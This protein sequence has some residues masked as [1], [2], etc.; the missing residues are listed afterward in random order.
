MRDLST[1]RGARREEIVNTTT[2]SNK[3]IL[4][5][6]PLQESDLATFLRTTLNPEVTPHI[7]P[8]YTPTQE[9]LEAVLTAQP[10]NN[11]RGLNTHHTLEIL[12]DSQKRITK[13]SRRI[14]D[15]KT[16]IKK[17]STLLAFLIDKDRP[18]YV[19][20]N[21]YMLFLLNLADELGWKGAEDYHWLLFDK[22]ADG[23]YDLLSLGPYD[24]RSMR[25]LDN[26]RLPPRCK[27]ACKK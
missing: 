4:G 21:Q 18:K 15:Q 3:D 20:Y 23:E 14:G 5:L 19:A 6:N 17:F 22:I 10:S 1:S 25:T 8:H 11:G 13:A 7:T 2:A 27:G 16:F 9:G 26:K 24:P 12:N